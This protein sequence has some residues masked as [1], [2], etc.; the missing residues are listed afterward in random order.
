MFH[1]IY[2]AIEKPYNNH[3]VP[4]PKELQDNGN[5]AK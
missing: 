3:K 5:E 2:R 4:R 1:L